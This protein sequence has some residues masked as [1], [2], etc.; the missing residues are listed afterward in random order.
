MF[1]FS[2]AFIIVLLIIVILIW[3]WNYQWRHHGYESIALNEMLDK[4]R[5]G[6]LILFKALDNS[7]GPKIGCYF[8]HIGVVWVSPEGVPYIF[9]AAG[10]RGM[11]LNTNQNQRGIFLE[12]LVDRI[13]RYR[14]YVFYKQLVG[15]LVV[16][17]AEFLEWVNYAICNMYYE[18][19]V[20]GNG[21][22]KGLGLEKCNNGTNCGEITMLTLIKLGILS[23]SEYDRSRPH[24]LRDMCYL[25]DCG[26]GNSYMEPMQIVFSPFG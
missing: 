16:D 11:H 7:N 12:P 15:P 25:E 21:I 22:K 20:V 4:V 13:I 17:D 14:G 9:E 1:D 24:H 8:C 23:E 5:T 26:M 6:D 19:D 10:T 2:I 3:I 18:Y